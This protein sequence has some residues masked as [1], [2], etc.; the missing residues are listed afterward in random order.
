MLGIAEIHAQN[1]LTRP[2]GAGKVKLLRLIEAR[3]AKRDPG[4]S[5]RD[6]CKP[7]LVGEAGP[8]T[9]QTDGA[10]QTDAVEGTLRY[11]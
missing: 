7:G 5:G 6:G 1:L 11:V 9:Q 2:N 3:I 4:T 10:S 8:R